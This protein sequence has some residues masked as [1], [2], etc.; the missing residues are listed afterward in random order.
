MNYKNFKIDVD[1]DGIALVTFDIPGR[2]MNVF[3]EGVV[4][5]RFRQD[6]GTQVKTKDAEIKGAVMTSGKDSFS[7]G[8]GPEDAAGAVVRHLPATKAR[9]WR[10]RA[11]DVVSTA[12]AGR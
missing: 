1:A 7:G 2:S 8:C 4:A 12:R 11:Q 3:D 10:R 6:R 5:P 9:I